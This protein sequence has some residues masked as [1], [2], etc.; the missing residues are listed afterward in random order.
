MAAVLMAAST[1]VFAIEDVTKG[2]ITVDEQVADSSR[3]Y[4]L[5]EVIVVSQP[6]ENTL[7]RRQPVS[8][9]MF[10]AT[11]M[12]RIGVRDIREL[13]SYVPSFAMP[14]YGSRITSSM[15]IRGIGSRVNSP[16][17]G[18]YVDGMPL[19]SKSAFNFHTYELE[20]VDVLRGPQGTLYGQNTEGGLVRM[21]SKSPM[22]YQGTD[23]NLG[24]GTRLYR[25]AEVAHYQK[26]SDHFAFSVA[27]FYSGQNGFFRNQL[28]GER[29][30][31]YNE[32]G[33]KLRMM[34]D[35]TR[36][37]SADYVADYQYVRQN[38]FPYGVMDQQ[39]GETA[40]PSTNYQNNYRRNAF[41]TAL[42]L[43]VAGRGFDFFSTTSYQYLRDYMQMD[44]DYL[45]ED[46]MHLEQRQFQNA[47]SQEFVFKSRN[48][49]RWHWT[50]GAYGSYTWLKTWAPVYFGDGITAPIAGGIQTAM[51]NAMVQSMAG[52]MAQQGL[53]P[54][55]AEAAAKQAIERAGGVAMEVTMY[56]PGLFHTPQYNIAFFHES[57]I[58][59]TDRLTATLGL[60][61]DHSHVGVEYDTEAAMAMTAHVM[62]TDAT[63]VLSSLLQHEEHNDYDQL[64]PKFGL[65]YRFGDDGSNVYATVSKGYR[66]GGFN[67]Q[68]FSDV[69]QTE[70]NANSQKAMRGSYDVPHT[71]QDYDNIRETIAYKPEVSWNYEFGTHL[72]LFDRSMQLDVSGFYMQVRNQQLTV[73]AGDYG[74]G[75]MMVNAGKSYS[76]GIEASLRG[77]LIA[78][79]LSWS[80]GYGYTRAVFKEYTD[81]I[82]VGGVEQT[83]DYKDKYVPYV[84]MHTFNAAA[85]YRF[86]FTAGALKAV[87][88]GAN[89][90]GQGKTWWDEANTC[91]QD[92]YAVLGAHADADF[93]WL[94]VSLWG[95]NLTDTRYN[96]FAVPSAASGTQYYFAQQGNPI[97]A[98]VDLKIHF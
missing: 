18:I 67:F 78:D 94:C 87:T 39:S 34:F 65:T 53:P 5:D 19:L 83:V 58:D 93:G 36:K 21:Y 8:S 61:Y 60:R 64:L 90:Y 55:A 23:I 82:T 84:P 80:A 89:V 26:V 37:V 6:K 96:T 47:F 10:D 22:R 29:A 69:L 43:K 75:R 17:V 1:Q 74:F 31:N 72:N 52:R 40:Q 98:G 66:A 79:H 71:E 41:N 91:G 3:V 7:L 25:K 32:A 81:Q 12:Q 92:V 30:D 9:A 88:V 57:N 95:R 68:M 42:N 49:S 56:V 62:G 16:A 76:C 24:I 38:G 35:I 86:D 4:D 27:G 59:L 51:Y 11:E 14:Q 77:H 46:Y 44:Q 15:Y 70:L 2:G 13:S 50:V 33:G 97:Q 20:R 48:N 45:P 28:T 63:Y 85:D 54:A 73:M